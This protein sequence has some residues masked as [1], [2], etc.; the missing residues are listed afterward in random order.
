MAEQFVP[1]AAFEPGG[2]RPLLDALARAGFRFE[3]APGAGCSY[4]DL[5]T[6]GLREGIGFDAVVTRF[7]VRRDWDI[8]MWPGRWLGDSG[9]AVP[10]C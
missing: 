10:R 3:P 2:L 7:G 1:P 8:T 6:N 5:D 4:Y 9:V